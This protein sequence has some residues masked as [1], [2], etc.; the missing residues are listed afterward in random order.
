MHR[1][2]WPGPRRAPPNLL[3]RS[4]TERGCSIAPSLLSPIELSGPT[5]PNRIVIAP[6]CQYSAEDGRATTWH[7][8][9]LGS[10]ALGGAGLLMLEAAAVEPR[11]QISP[12]DLGLHDDACEQALASLF[13]L[14]AAMEGYSAGTWSAPFI[15]TKRT[16]L[17][18]VSMQSTGTTRS[19]SGASSSACRLPHSHNVM[20]T[21]LRLEPN[22]VTV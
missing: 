13:T 7:L 14:S 9:H 15:A 1:K 2:C 20:I 16:P 3:A 6:M 22:G 21:A 10:L 4:R 8:I 18:L 12:A 11:G 19:E 17:E 5:L